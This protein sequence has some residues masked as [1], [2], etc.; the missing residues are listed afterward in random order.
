MAWFLAVIPRWMEKLAWILRLLE[1]RWTI[2][3]EAKSTARRGS[4]QSSAP[5]LLRP[6]LM[7]ISG[8][9]E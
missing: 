7:V 9:K 6:V 8:P 5:I 3:M 2:C 4:Y 1:M